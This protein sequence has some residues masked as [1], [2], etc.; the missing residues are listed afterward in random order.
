MLPWTILIGG[1]YTEALS[2]AQLPTKDPDGTY[3]FQSPIGNGAFHLV[4]LPQYGHFTRWV[5]D[6]PSR[7]IG[8]EISLGMYSVTVKELAESFTRVTGKKARAAPLPVQD[9]FDMR[10][11]PSDRMIPRSAKLSDNDNSVF[12]F[13]GSMSHFFGGIMGRVLAVMQCSLVV[14]V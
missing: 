7:S 5:L 13:R 11:I 12:T 10:R 14:D 3:V 9:W 8:K 6:N 2:A 4:D 1:Y